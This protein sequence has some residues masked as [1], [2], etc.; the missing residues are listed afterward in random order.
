M[1]DIKGFDDK[2]IEKINRIC[3]ILQR[4]SL[5]DYTQERLSL[6]GGTS[7]NFLH[8]KNIPRLSLDIDF[9]YRDLTTETWE[10][11]R[12]TIDRI[13]KKNPIRS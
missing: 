12:D 5:V 3:D 10:K 9:N 1:A 6:Y 13:I 8:F 2:T 7:L 11:E 4:V